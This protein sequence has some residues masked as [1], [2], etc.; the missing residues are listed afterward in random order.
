M[1][2]A[3][4][5]SRFLGR[6]FTLWVLVLAFLA[7]RMPAQFSTIAP[8]VPLLLGII[9]FGMGLTLTVNDFKGVLT[10][11][12][13]VAVGVLAQFVIMPGLAFMLAL[14]F[15]LPPE[16][17]TGVILVGCCPGGTASNV[18]T[19]LAKGNTALSVT[20]TACTTLLAPVA[21]PFLV[22]LLAGRWID[23]SASAMFWA[24]IKIVLL[25]VLLGVALRLLFPKAVTRSLDLL[26]T[27]SIIGIVLVVAA[28]VAVNQ[29]NLAS[30]GL[31]VMGV[32]MLHN[33]LGLAL[34]Y[35]AARALK[36]DYPERKAISIEVG[37]QNSGLGA[38]LALA[39]FSPG[40]AIPS[41]LFSVWHNLSGPAL[42]TWW[43]RR[44]TKD[45]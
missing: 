25:P 37:M 14:L 38:T 32:V 8:Q 42:A 5:L 31:L 45:F 23:I 19:Y 17:A 11:P 27:V 43:R 10:M 9:M 1:N 35:L 22:W 29:K 40:A 4:K 33:T 36:L 16:L 18:M 39:Y 30:S 44:A 3:S 13:S 12:K 20:M 34:G 26:P 15:R 6:T 2:A 21:T 24:I 7:Y 41:A 28:V